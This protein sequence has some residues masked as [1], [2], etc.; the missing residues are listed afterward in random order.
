[1]ERYAVEAWQ[2]SGWRYPSLR[3]LA[4]DVGRALLRPG[5]RAGHAVGAGDPPRET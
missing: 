3:K 1:M 5:S 2:A 4:V